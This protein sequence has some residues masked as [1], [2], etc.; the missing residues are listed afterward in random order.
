MIKQ[1]YILFILFGLNSFSQVELAVQKGHSD[2]IVQLEFSNSSRYLASL[3]ANNEIIIWQVGIEK[4][5]SSFKIGEIEM[6]EGLKFT[7]D[8]QKLK[9][10]EQPIFMT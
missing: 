7:E 10:L 4:A 8:E 6:I 3:A 5:L 2:D 1:L 9:P